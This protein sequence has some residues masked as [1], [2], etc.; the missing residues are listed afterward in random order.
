MSEVVAR[1]ARS[2]DGA[3]MGKIYCRS[4]QRGYREML[5]DAFLDA[6]TD[7]TVHPRSL[8]RSGVLSRSGGTR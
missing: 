7:G 2:E 6:L 4:W 1:E 8:R 3:A 5:P